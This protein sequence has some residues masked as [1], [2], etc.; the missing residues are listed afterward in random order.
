MSLDPLKKHVTQGSVHIL[1]L[2]NA[3]SN[4]SIKKPLL[5]V[6]KSKILPGI[7]PQK[8]SDTYNQLGVKQQSPTRQYPDLPNTR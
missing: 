8:T 2:H 3:T 5:K 4:S 6:L 1:V 7:L